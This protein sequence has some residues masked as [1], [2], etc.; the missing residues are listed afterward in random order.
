M[1][2]SEAAAASGCHLETIRYYEREGLI[3]PPA[4]ARNG[5]RSYTSD[6]IERLRFISRG[7]E[8]GFSLDEIR[9]LLRLE[10]DRSL[11]CDEI[12]AIARNHLADIRGKVRELNRI[13]RELDRTIGA[14][15]GGA[16]G[17]CSILA[18]LRA[19]PPASRSKTVHV[20]KTQRS[21]VKRSPK[22]RR[23][24]GGA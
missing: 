21:G 22:Q 13:A 16:R 14:C 6:E 18:T 19:P 12:D 8:L 4:R 15:S 24:R 9:S 3:P 17:Q 7:R 11:S 2:I 20:S 5:Y 23:E 10:H 1:K